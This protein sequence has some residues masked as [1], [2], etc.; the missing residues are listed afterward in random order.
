MLGDDEFV[1][2]LHATLIQKQIRKYHVFTF[3]GT[4]RLGIYDFKE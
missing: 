4:F 2:E 3:I 1:Q